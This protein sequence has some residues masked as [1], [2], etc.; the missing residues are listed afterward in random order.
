MVIDVLA[1]ALTDIQQYLNDPTYDR[2]YSG[3]LR[4]EIERVVAEM[5]SLLGRLDRLPSQAEQQQNSG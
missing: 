3:E 1:D 4:A 5:Q 2:I